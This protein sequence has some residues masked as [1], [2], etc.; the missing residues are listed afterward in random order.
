MYEDIMY[1]VYTVGSNICTANACTAML[2]KIV[3]RRST[4]CCTAKFYDKHNIFETYIFFDCK[5]RK[6]WVVKKK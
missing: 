4:K 3:V 6:M 2:K 1:K 5:L